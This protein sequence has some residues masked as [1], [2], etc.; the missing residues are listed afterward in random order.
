MSYFGKNFE[1]PNK[2]FSVILANMKKILIVF[3]LFTFCKVYGQKTY[4]I[5]F[6]DSTP[7]ES[8]KEFCAS[9]S[10][11]KTS[12]KTKAGKSLT[13]SVS[14]LSSKYS[15]ADSR[16]SRIYKLVLSEDITEEAFVASISPDI[17]LEYFE[18]SR[19]YQVDNIPNDSLISKQWALNK[20]NV[21]EAWKY[22][23]GSDSLIVGIVDTG[24]DFN[25][26]DLKH[27][28]YFNDGE[29]GLD[30]NDNDKSTN[31]IDDDGNG[32]V[33][34]YMGWDFTNRAG[35]PFDS[36]GGDYLG[37]DNYPMDDNLYSHGTAVAGIIGAETNN[38]YGIAGVAPKVRLLNC[39][40]FDPDG[41]GN[42]DDVASAILYATSMGAKVINMSFGDNSF[43]YV[44]R[45]VIRYA[46]SK[47]V[48]LVGSAG[49]DGSNLPHYPSSYSEVISVGN[50]TLEDYV[51]STSSYG[52]TLDVIAPGTEI[53][54]AFKGDKYYE[55]NGTSAS[56]P[57]VAAEAA[58]ILSMKSFTNEEVKQIIKSTC[59]DISG[60]GWNVRSGAGRINIEKAL[61]VL[62]PAIV[63]FNYPYQNYSTSSDT[64]N[65]YS[66]VLSPNFKSFSLYYGYT[67]NP[68]SWVPLSEGILNQKDN[69]LIAKLQLGTMPDTVIT[70][71]LV[72]KQSNGIDLEERININRI[73]KCPKASLLSLSPSFYGDKS[74]IIAATYT[75]QPGV[76]KMFYREVGATDFNFVSLDGL[77]V[78]TFFIKTTHYGFIPITIAKPNTEYEIYF[79]FENLVGLK[80]VLLDSASQLFTRV[81]PP[82][83][84][85][86]PVQ[87][88]P[89]NKLPQGLMFGKTINLTG[90]SDKYVLI[91]A[92][93]DASKTYLYLFKNDS[94]VLKD[95]ITQ[96]IPKDFGYFNGNAN[97]D[98]LTNWGRNLYILEQSS[99]DSTRFVEKYKKENS[100]TWPILVSDINSDG[101]KELLTVSND[102]TI[103]VFKV[104]PSLTLDSL[105]SAYNFATNYRGVFDYPNA[106]VTDLDKN[107]KH[108]V[109]ICDTYGNV[110]C[111]NVMN[112][113]TLVPD[114][115]RS[116][117][118]QF[119]SS[120]ST[121]ASGD[122]DGDGNTEIAVLLHSIDKYDIAK[123]SLLAVIKFKNNVPFVQYQKVFVDPAAEFNI[124]SRKTYNSLKFADVDGDGSQELIACIFPY[125]YIIRNSN[126]NQ[127][128]VIYY[129]DNVNSNAIIDS[130]FNGDGIV[131][132][133]ISKNDGISFFQFN[134]GTVSNI[135]T[136]VNASSIDS[137]SISIT[138]SGASAKYFVLR[139]NDSLSFTLIDSTSSLSYLD[140]GLVNGNMYYYKISISRNGEYRYSSKVIKVKSHTPNKVIA[141]KE[142]SDLRS[143]SVQFSGLMA[144]TLSNLTF[145]HLIDSLGNGHYPTSVSVSSQYSYQLF[146][147]AKLS[148]G[149]YRFSIAGLKDLFGSEVSSDT[150]TIEFVDKNPVSEFYIESF[151]ILDSYSIQLRFNLPVDLISVLNLNNYTFTP[152]NKVSSASID[153]TDKKVIRLSLRGAKPIGSIGIDYVLHLNDIYSDVSSGKILIRSGAGSVAKLTSYCEDLRSVFS[154]PNPVVLKGGSAKITFANLPKHAEI[155]IYDIRG[156]KVKT[157]TEADGNG[158]VDWDLID[159]NGKVL[160][161]GVYLYY[162]RQFNSNSEEISTKLQKFTV[163]K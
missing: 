6:A 140:K 51:A 162:V 59:D 125:C 61:R 114:T 55:F 80:T 152:S 94:F 82:S 103:S 11:L 76:A 97:T 90:N 101:T 158:G 16:V 3:L 98:L 62:A 129:S 58:L 42:E 123:F 117:E 23:Q 159:D 47:N 133:G 105:K 81:T 163:V 26:V 36:L 130:D 109:W 145:F 157:V 70:L 9:K 33:D 135:P 27:K 12:A 86:N 74:T 56:A 78:N 60:Q 160:S 85:Y 24:I 88:M 96:R 142:N 104:N 2:G 138:W 18:P 119:L 110:L 149:R 83:I 124:F 35:F 13:Y 31:G 139:S 87:T 37:W 66:T 121:L 44:L 100:E 131:E 155:I 108:Q 73:T 5:K 79:E 17:N 41:Y 10:I 71:R 141:V 89:Y 146:F 156:I 34:D 143:V 77:S 46:Y 54:T 127:K 7:L 150:V 132:L 19:T 99:P 95:S 28:I 29:M 92:I 45:D 113:C 38:L 144:T 93:D 53:M 65:I 122:F 91:N 30:A 75:N 112:D 107:G 40:A 15:I 39:R 161:S 106:L 22:T 4:F 116:V 72:L 52:S 43:S 21:F 115:I 14:S 134:N 69:S 25:H 137:A 1:Y 111:Y 120:S 128:D 48:V 153:N 63:R 126:I 118:T 148:T 154:Y 67:Y 8:V 151:S 68:T 50:S 57:F 32:F 64:V 136:D 84:E 102:S 20:I 147:D 49:N